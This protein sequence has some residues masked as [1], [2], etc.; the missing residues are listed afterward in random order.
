MYFTTARN[1]FPAMLNLPKMKSFR[2]VYLIGISAAA[3]F[4]NGCL[5]GP[6]YKT[7]APAPNAQTLPAGYKEDPTKFKGGEGWRV[8]QPSDAM[9]RGAWWKIFHDSE[10]DSLENSLEIND[11]N[12]K[13]FFENFMEARALV[14]E[15]NSQLYPTITASASYTRSLSASTRDSTGASAVSSALGAAST[16]IASNPTTSIMTSLSLTWEADI[17]GKLR[18]QLR[19]Q[20][21]TAQVSAADLENERLSEESSLAVFYFELRGQDALEKLFMDT[22]EADKKAL[23][24]TQNQY[25]TGITD[26]IGVVQAQNTL[27]NAEATATNLG[28]LRAQYEHAIAVLTGRIA[29]NF[30]IPARPLD[31][32]P[33]SVPIGLPAQLLERRPDIAAAERT[34]AAANAQIGMSEAAYFPSVTL[35]GQ[36]GFESNK[37]P[38]LFDYNNRNWSTG[39][40]ISETVF[41]AGLR[42]ATVHQFIATYNADLAGYRETVLTA[43][44]QVENSLSQVRILSKQ[45]IEQHAAVD[46]AEQFLKLENNR[47]QTGIDPYVDVVTAQTTLLSDQQTEIDVKV[48]EM[49]GAVQLIEALGGGWDRSQLPSP[50]DV[51]KW[52]SRQETAIQH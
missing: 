24:Y 41:D 4:L 45:A 29:S 6:R 36:G 51:S 35:G 21:Y 50:H 2:R 14:S 19:A 9:L 52:P 48:Q 43:F 38:N 27:Q 37:F 10:L 5:I 11:Q 15:A 49:T 20:Q 16:A 28:V 8:A 13:Q 34:M 33:P 32:A 17:W 31:A 23:E 3:L 39:P 42:T 26:Q 7:P 46:S 47:Y 18:N 44:E 12:I 1:H 40:E 25:K 30:S 22:I